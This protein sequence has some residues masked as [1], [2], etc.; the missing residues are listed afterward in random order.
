M[1]KPILLAALLCFGSAAQAQNTDLVEAARGTLAAIQKNSFKA[2]RE[3]CGMIGRNPAGNIVISRPRKGRADSCR[4]RNFWRND[5]EVVAS[6][7][8]HG[9][10]D[11][12]SDAELPSVDDLRADRQEQVLGFVSTPGGRFWIIEPELNRVRML[13]GRGCLP[14]DPLYNPV[15]TGRVRAEYT[16]RQLINRERG[17]DD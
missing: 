11:P 4:P 13:C 17:L 2:N 5:I 12:D 9:S 6:Y 10:H 1:T 3:Y 14:S 15:D 16:E 7:H 8:T